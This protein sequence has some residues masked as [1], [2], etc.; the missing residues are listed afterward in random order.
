[1]PI[2]VQCNSCGKRLR[3]P[4]NRTGKQVRC[5]QCKETFTIPAAQTTEPKG[6]PAG[7]AKAPAP[8]PR[9]PAPSASPQAAASNV[10]WTVQLPDG[11]QFGP[12]PKT[13][14]DEWL[15]E[16][17]L[18][19]KCQVLREGWD[20]WKWADEVF[21]ELTGGAD[22]ESEMTIDTS[23]NPLAAMGAVP[24]LTDGVAASAPAVDTG[25]PYAVTPS[26]GSASSG[27]V[28]VVPAGIKRAM[29][30][31]RP[32][33]LFLSIVIFVVC[34]LTMLATIF[35]M[36]TALSTGMSTFIV[37]TLGI[38]FVTI[39]STGV[40]FY[41]GYLLFTYAKKI[42]IFGRRNSIHDLQN[43]IVAQR[44]FWKYIG[45]VTL[46]AVVLYGLLILAMIFM[47]MFGAPAASDATRS[48][49]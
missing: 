43:A 3:A 4:D 29:S 25:N 27:E 32:W 41:G 20:Q 7:R 23:S 18:D 38:A 24:S 34:A 45:I 44:S 16:G 40:Y 31:T 17:R 19:S 5:P 35:I 48:F 22:D 8:T 1:V 26:D 2:D 47:F 11:E 13:D 39:L 21:P 9:A 49:R 37:L 46:V 15:R 6:N 14:R 42:D 30:E 33:V 36:V 10:T 12:V 28:E